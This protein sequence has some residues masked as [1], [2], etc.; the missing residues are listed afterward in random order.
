MT[1]TTNSLPVALR[2]WHP[3]ASSSDLVPRH[4]YQG[5]LHGREL[6][7]WRADDGFVNVWKT[8]AC[9]GACG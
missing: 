9:T 6:A 2:A 3:V 4:V 1:S 5:E 7:V 8:A